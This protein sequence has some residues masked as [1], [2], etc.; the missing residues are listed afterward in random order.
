MEHSMTRLALR[1]QPLGIFGLPA[2]YLVLPSVS[3]AAEL[4][5]ELLQGQ[6]PH[7]VA[8]ALQFY[9]LA[10]E[11]D[12]EAALNV[13]GDDQ[14]LEARYNRFVLNSDPISYA[15][16]QSELD[17]DLAILLAVV[18]YT[19]GWNDAPPAADTL[20]GELAACVLSAQAAYALEHERDEVA[21]IA[22]NQ[23]IDAVRAI[24][25]LLAAQLLGDLAD[26]RARHG[27]G[28]LAIQHYHEA[29]RLL[30]GR[31]FPDLRAQ[32]SLRLGM[33][34]QD[35][36]HGQR[37]G[38]LEAVKCY[39]EALHFYTRDSAPELYALAQNNLALA[40]LAMPL[41][42]ASDQLRMAI[43]VQSLREALT[44][45]TR[46]DYPER[47]SS[48]QLNLANSLQYLPSAHPEDHLAEAV[49]LYEELLAARNPASDPLGSARLLANQGNALAHL[50][51]FS[52]AHSKLS[53]A[54]S[55]FARV[56]D[57]ASVA[58]VDELLAT[59]GQQAHSGE[60]EQ[61]GSI[62]A[63]TV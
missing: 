41:V 57:S 8:P 39:Q 50:G 34:Y 19:L 44:V 63:A 20:N 3:G 31:G 49:E 4:Q 42:E 18:G 46:E 17:G 27:N 56:G 59:I 52:H 48:A 45:Y 7:A 47:W 40:Y 9:T 24:S 58:T 15:Q 12:L 62:P 60:V 13:L 10:L 22:L 32:L 33:L 26:L 30:N 1:P 16:L 43:A 14:T 54:R 29:L 2:G 53:D 61:Y 6:V 55:L 23:A 11:G 36:A 25:P 51:I 21:M 35:L 28:P 37:G 5:A 38:L